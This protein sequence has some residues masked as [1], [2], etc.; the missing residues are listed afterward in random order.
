M[1]WVYSNSTG[2]RLRLSIAAV[3]AAVAGLSDGAQK[4]VDGVAGVGGVL[5]VGIGEVGGAHQA[6]DSDARLARE[7]MEHQHPLA[8]AVGAHLEASA[9]GRERVVAVGP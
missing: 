1:G 9:V 7:V 6:I 3:V 4:G 5:L 8:E 2:G